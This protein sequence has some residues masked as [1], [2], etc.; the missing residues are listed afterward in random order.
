MAIQKQTLMV[1]VMAA[2]IAVS[3]ISIWRQLRPSPPS[4]GRD[5]MQVVGELAAEETVR[6][7]GGTGRVVV[8]RMPTDKTNVGMDSIQ[9]LR[10]KGF[11]R[12]LSSHDRI[13]IVAVMDMITQDAPDANGEAGMA[14]P[15]DPRGE[16]VPAYPD[17]DAIV[18]LAGNPFSA[19]FTKAGGSAKRPIRVLM[20]I[21]PGGEELVRDG[22]ADVAFILSQST[23]PAPGQPETP[24]EWFD[25]LYEVVARD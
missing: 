9:A 18:C 8:L 16:T 13:Q 15:E 25:L 24:R 10:L 5:A 1:M 14:S 4:P 17:A 22:V 21:I 3:T 23:S 12:A 2:I 20:E 11:E 19:D 7:L 6:L